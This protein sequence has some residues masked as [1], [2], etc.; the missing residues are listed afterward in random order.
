MRRNPEMILAAFALLMGLAC[1]ALASSGGSPEG[2]EIDQN[3]GWVHQ[4]L[5]GEPSEP[6]P[7]LPGVELVQQD[8]GEFNLGASVWGTP[9]TLGNRKYERGFG[10]HAVSVIRVSLPSPARRFLAEVGVDNNNNTGGARGSVEFSLEADGVEVWRSGLRTCPENALAVDVELDNASTL[11][12]RVSDGGDGPGWD[13]ADW[14]DAQVEL[15]KGDTLWLDDLPVTRPPASLGTGLPFSF[16]ADG[17]S[18]R[19]FLSGWEKKVTRQQQIGE[20][21]YIDVAFTSPDGNLQVRYLGK[22]YHDYPAVDW[23]LEFSNLGQSPS[24]LLETIRPLDVRL[25][26]N[27][28]NEA[29]LHHS[30]GSTCTETDF[31]PLETKLERGQTLSLKP[32]G[33]R[34]SDGVLPFFNLATVQGGLTVAIGWA[35]QWQLDVARDDAGISL[36]AGQQYAR[37]RLQPGETVRTPRLLVVN[38]AGSEPLHGNNL[39]RRLL[40]D[41]Y[42]PRIEGAPVTPLVYQNTWFACNTGNDVTE[43]NQI[44]SIV[45]MESQGNEGYWLDAGWFEGGWPSGAGSWFPRKDAFPNGLG[46]VFSAAHERGMKVVLWFEPERVSAGTRIAN[47]HPEWVLRANRD[48]AQFV[49]V[50]PGDGL[51]DLSNP[52]AERWLT[53]YLVSCV[54]DW[55]IDVYRNDFNIDPLRFWRGA[56]K[57]EREGIT[58]IR[59]V[60]ALYRLWDAILNARP[61]VSIDNCS[62]GGR[63]IELELLTR[64][65]P[66]WRSDT[67]C[68]GQ[69]MPIQDQTQT[70]G[71]S[72]YVPLHAAGVWR[73]DPYTWWSV[74]TTGTSICPDTIPMTKELP[75]I[76]ERIR[77]TKRL[78]PLWLGDY[79]PLAP[80]TSMK[81]DWAAW[82]FD[83]ADLGEG[84]AMWFRRPDS[85]Y[86]A[87]EA[88]LQA[89]DPDSTY[90]LEWPLLGEKE[91]VSGQRLA[92]LTVSLP[93]AETMSLL[94]YKKLD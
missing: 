28:L 85:P 52:E 19:E 63:R 59:Y 74:A 33:G 14:C 21:E 31:I 35:G 61:G 20:I 91:R 88:G 17:V 2:H 43:A 68:C 70:A 76:Q 5:L 90:E 51:F 25:Q 38:W 30:Y 3:A 82:Q 93:E 26:T 64:S 46:P 66:L 6:L 41:H 48:D 32:N 75:A 57:P 50:A 69:A 67:Q 54:R 39:M 13:Q 24:A 37:F 47:E 22:L 44:A 81:S 11:V 8:Y 34:P 83:R 77:E 9:L 60:E 62:S 53:D 36:T 71:L 29:V 87:V 94:I 84:F 4:S 58:E 40:V 18:S 80:I 78:R 27:A 1:F 73:F 45:Q 86:S 79:Y 55:E 12:L 65:V 56:D 15:T 89:I 7:V 49:E 16:L 92:R 23:V 10:T 42:V 72:L